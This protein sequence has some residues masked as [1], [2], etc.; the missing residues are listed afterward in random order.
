MILT[1]K[2]LLT[3]AQKPEAQKRRTKSRLCVVIT[4]EDG[5]RAQYPVE[6]ESEA[7]ALYRHYSN[8]N[9]SLQPQVIAS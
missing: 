4:F 9:P 5:I 3:G 6:N 1:H 8:M 7:L 2:K